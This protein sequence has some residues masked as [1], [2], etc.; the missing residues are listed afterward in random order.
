MRL[1]NVTL[2]VIAAGWCWFGF[3]YKSLHNLCTLCVCLF[4][5]ADAYFL[6]V[7][8]FSYFYCPLCDLYSSSFSDATAYSRAYFGQGNGSI[9]LDD[10]VC[11]GNETRLVDCRYSAIHNCVHGE[12][13][14]ISCKA[15][16]EFKWFTY[17]IFWQNLHHFYLQLVTLDLASQ[18]TLVHFVVAK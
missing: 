18:H 7:F 1:I 5:I 2:K 14:G 12:D 10:V 13:A 11:V 17:K 6:S 8:I 16:R 4:Y 9:V 15:E 3:G